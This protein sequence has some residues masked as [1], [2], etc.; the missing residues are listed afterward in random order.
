MSE[1]VARLLH[2]RAST[3]A[4]PSA[5]SGALNT[6]NPPLPVEDPDTYRCL[7]ILVNE[8]GAYHEVWLTP[9]L[10]RLNE[11]FPLLA[12]YERQALISQLLVSPGAIWAWK[13][14]RA[15]PILIPW[16]LS[17]GTTPLY[18]QVNQTRLGETIAPAAKASVEE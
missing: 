17:T 6:F 7:A 1:S 12:N 10:R 15:T 5:A 18:A 13:S 14:A 9:F 8:F 3:R 2:A 4:E 16:R 11:A